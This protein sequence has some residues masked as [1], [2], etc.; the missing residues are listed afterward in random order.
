MNIN[1]YFEDVQEYIKSNIQNPEEINS[2]IKEME[3]DNLQSIVNQDFYSGISIEECGDKILKNTKIKSVID[4][5]EPDKLDGD[6]ALNTMERKILKFN[7]FINEN[8][9]K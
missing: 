3:K 5:N 2:I 1:E 8:R 6:R 7:N 9:R 4:I